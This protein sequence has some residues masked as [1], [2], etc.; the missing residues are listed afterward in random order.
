MSIATVMDVVRHGEGALY[1]LVNVAGGAAP[2]TWMPSTRVTRQDWRDLFAANLET[3]FFMS[4]AVA[5]EIRAQGNPGSIVSVS[6]ISGMNSAPFHVPTAPPKRRSW[7]PPEHSPRSLPPEGIRVNA[8][9]PRCHRDRRLGDV[10]RR[11]SRP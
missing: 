8:V 11:R 4:Q 6:S 1:G 10:C 9:A 5:A 2:S 3:M 7:P